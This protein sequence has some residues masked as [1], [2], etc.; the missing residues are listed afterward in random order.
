M[1]R[2]SVPLPCGGTDLEQ[3]DGRDPDQAAIETR[4]PLVIGGV[5]DVA[6]RLEREF[7]DNISGDSAQLLIDFSIR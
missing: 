6:G 2:W 3:G 7:R 1:S 4:E 5:D